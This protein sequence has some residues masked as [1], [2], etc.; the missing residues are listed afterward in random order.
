MSIIKFIKDNLEF[1]NEKVENKDNNSDLKFKLI[2]KKPNELLTFIFQGSGS[3]GN[4]YKVINHTKN[5]SEIPINKSV[6]LKIMKKK[7]DELNR[8]KLIGE[9]ISK[10][11]DRYL[12]NK[13]IMRINNIDY[14]KNLVFLECIDGFTLKDYVKKN[15][16]TESEFNI[17]LLKAILCIKTMHNVLN[18]SHRDIKGPNIVYDPNK[19]NMKCIDYG[20]VVQLDDD[21]YKNRYNGTGSYIHPDMNK[22]R[23][24]MKKNNSLK[25]PDYVSQDLFATIIM[26]LKL[27]NSVLK[28]NSKTKNNRIY[29]NNTK[30]N[31]N[32]M[33][34]IFQ[35]IMN[36]Y[37]KSIGKEKNSNSRNIKEK[38]RFYSKKKLLDK[39]LY[40]D[41]NRINNPV[42]R[43]IIKLLK[44]HWDESRTDFCIN[45]KNNLFITNFIFD[46]LV[47]NIFK[48]LKP[49]DEKKE[50]YYDWCLIYNHKLKKLT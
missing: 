6:I 2:Y 42:I 23:P 11:K 50:L 15:I 28:V 3:F 10:I 44:E 26:L 17:L 47:F 30:K 14:D 5:K 4:V 32:N 16:L 41:E 49:S 18:F 45:K 31:R 46:S 29:N 9:M 13:Y 27:Y 25:Y 37:S 43:E 24:R 7:N 36:K 19:K 12:I 39:F 22:K 1:I 40:I 21:S 34:D 20:F 48:V 33:D 38:I 8:L 35:D